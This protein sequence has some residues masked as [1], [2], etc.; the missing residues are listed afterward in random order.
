MEY[1]EHDFQSQDGLRLYYREYG[2]GGKS[3]ICLPG[4]TRNSK[5]FQDI[6]LHLAPNYRVI[7]PDLRGR[8]Q[9][10]PDPNW[11]NYNVGVYA[12]DVRA[13]MKAAQ[14]DR[15]IFLGTS[16]GGLVT[17]ILAYQSPERIQAAI[18]NDLGPEVDPAGYQR[19]LA[20]AGKQVIEVRSWPDAV[21]QCK[22]KYGIA[23]PEMP[24]EFWEDFAR[25]SY[26]EGEDGA[27]EPDIDPKIGDAI[28]FTARAGKVL[29]FLNKLK[30]VREVRG[31]PVD[32]WM[33]FRAMTMPCL[34]LR[35]A[36]SDILS[37]EIIDRMQAVKPDLIRATIPER[38][39]APVLDEPASLAAI[40]GFLAGLTA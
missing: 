38:G 11:K 25:K 20:S 8:G 22:E 36:T 33:A 37:E 28:R 16:L 9:S 35:G 32:P 40:D 23:F 19:I 10:D 6:A 24:A 12:Q 27:P 7:C 13:L 39:H 2:A 34:V 18:L 30:L 14:I 21:E 1:Q 4:L 5:D 26:R 29:G 17:M 31:V 3:I 15:A